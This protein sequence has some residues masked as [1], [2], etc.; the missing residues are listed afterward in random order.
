MNIATILRFLLV[1]CVESNRQVL[2][3]SSSFIDCYSSSCSFM[4]SPCCEDV[5]L[6]R[7][8]DCFLGQQL[9]LGRTRCDIHSSEASSR[10]MTFLFYFIFVVGIGV[11]GVL[12]RLSPINNVRINLHQCTLHWGPLAES[13]TIMVNIDGRR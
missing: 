11:T 6:K 9:Q 2:E 4:K 7:L 3:T 1:H 5:S 13:W 8:R 12:I 10:R